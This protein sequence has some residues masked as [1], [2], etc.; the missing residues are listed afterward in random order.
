MFMKRVPARKF[1]SYVTE[2]QTKGQEAR[3]ASLTS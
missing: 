3:R 2:A 1:D